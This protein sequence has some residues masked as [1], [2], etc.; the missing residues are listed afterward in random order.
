MFSDIV[1]SGLGW[2]R[3]ADYSRT[4]RRIRC[5]TFQVAARPFRQERHTYRMDLSDFCLRRKLILRTCVVPS[6]RLA[7]LPH[8][9]LSPWIGGLDCAP[10]LSIFRCAGCCGS[11]FLGNQ[12][13]QCQAHGF[14]LVNS[15]ESLISHDS[16]VWADKVNS[17]RELIVCSSTESAACLP[18]P[19]TPTF[20]PVRGSYRIS[21]LPCSLFAFRNSRL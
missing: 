21:P 20:P 2:R 16:K 4:T 1:S 18:A 15:V 12:R 11:G 14:T 7:G 6:H 13:R 19:Y 3:Y 10:F 5:K 17:R 9:P 8:G